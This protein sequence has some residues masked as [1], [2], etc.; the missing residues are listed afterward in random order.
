MIVA[1]GHAQDFTDNVNVSMTVHKNFTMQEDS[2]TITV[3]YKGHNVVATIIDID[4][5]YWLLAI[6]GHLSTTFFICF[7]S[8][9]KI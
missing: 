4:I 2:V 1:L 6:I 3:V 7:L 9:F 5:S 8:Y